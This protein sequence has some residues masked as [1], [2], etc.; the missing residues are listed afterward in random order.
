MDPKKKAIT[1]QTTAITLK[2]IEA[3]GKGTRR[4]KE[5]EYMVAMGIHWG[6]GEGVGDDDDEDDEDD[7][8]V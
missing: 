8:E 7:D 5:G 1:V 3:S 6:E 2:G 4:S